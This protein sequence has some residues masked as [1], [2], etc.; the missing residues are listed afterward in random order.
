MH[1]AN[2]D[3]HLHRLLAKQLYAEL[4]L[5]SF[6]HNPDSDTV[7]L[8]QSQLIFEQSKFHSHLP[9]NFESMAHHEALDLQP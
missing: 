6:D 2:A 9:Q 5:E 7:Y 1:C 4:P 8:H 3:D